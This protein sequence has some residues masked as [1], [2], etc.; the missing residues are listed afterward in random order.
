MKYRDG[1]SVLGTRQ[2]AVLSCIREQGPMSKKALC[3]MLGWEK[4]HPTIELQYTLPGLISKGLIVSVPMT[5]F[6]HQQH[7]L[8][9]GHS[10]AKLSLYT[11]VSEVNMVISAEMSEVIER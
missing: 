4:S 11:L 2:K 3:R 7:S 10:N 5:K 1:K 8:R 6:Q 9:Y